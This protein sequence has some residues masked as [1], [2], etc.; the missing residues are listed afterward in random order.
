MS[1]S[2][3]DQWSWLFGGFAWLH[4]DQFKNVAIEILK[5]MS[6]YQ[7]VVL[8]VLVSCSATDSFLKCRMAPFRYLVSIVLPAITIYFCDIRTGNQ[9]ISDSTDDP[10]CANGHKVGLCLWGRAPDG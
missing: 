3:R 1:V 7:P 9:S 5:S 4:V 6:V 2:S 10:F 8:W